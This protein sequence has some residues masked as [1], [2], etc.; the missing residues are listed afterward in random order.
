MSIGIIVLNFLRKNWFLISILL[1][2]VFI[3]LY[4]GSLKSEVEDL[5]FEIRTKNLEIDECKKSIQNR[6]DIIKGWSEKTVSEND[7]MQKL[8]TDIIN[9]TKN[10][11]TKIINVLKKNTPKTCDEA[12]EYF[13]E[14]G[15]KYE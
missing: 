1:G 10:V 3:Y 2:T 15:K 13:I 9:L 7:K 5:K 12:I 14:L 4:I 6:N 8:R 11:D